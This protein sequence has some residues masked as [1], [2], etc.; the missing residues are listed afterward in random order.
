M[1]KILVEVCAGSLDDAFAAEQGGADRIEINSALALGGLTPSIGL[2]ETIQQHCQIPM[3][4]MA[5][6]RP[7]DFCYNQHEMDVLLREVETLAAKSIA[8]FAFGLTDSSHR[9][10]AKKCRRLM[11]AVGGDFD[12]V[13]HRAFDIAP[14]WQEAIEVIIDVGCQRLLTSGQAPTAEQGTRLLREMVDKYGD[15]IEII[16]GSGVNADNV[17][18]IIELSGCRQV[19]GSFCGP[20]KACRESAA[21][22][23]DYRCTDA[24]SVAQIVRFAND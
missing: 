23:G 8:G 17:G 15:R 1:N 3:I 9:V 11:D 22:F 16:A 13:F 12:F 2:V 18:S 24:D 21:D 19:H 4:A 14:D 20:A 6:P 7:G 10:D 5:R